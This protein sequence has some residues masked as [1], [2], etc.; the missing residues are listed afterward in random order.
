MFAAMG[1]QYQRFLWWKKYLTALQMVQFVAIMVHA[2]QLL[3]IDCNYP[4]AFVWW[5]GMHAV[6][7]FFLF[8]EFYKSTYKAKQDRLRREAEKKRIDALQNGIKQNGSI[9]ENGIN[10]NG[11]KHLNGTISNGS[12]H[13]HLENGN[14]IANGSV[15]HKTDNY[16]NI[17]S[18]TDLT[19]RKVQK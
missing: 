10:E 6:M 19:R 5:I 11:T 7:F 14:G 17:D 13:K 12:V 2:F 4:R 16:S 18:P 9:K 3:F 1:P 8:N 15:N